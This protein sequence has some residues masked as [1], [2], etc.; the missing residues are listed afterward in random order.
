MR[1]LI[2]EEPPSWAALWSPRIAWLSVLVSLIALVLVRYGFVD[3]TP[4]VAAVLSGLALALGAVLL[5]LW[6]FVRIWQEG[7]RGVAS[8]VAGL[9][10]GLLV[11]AYPAFLLARGAFLP[12]LTDITTDIAEPPAFSRSRAA[13]TARGGWVP[14]EIAPELRAR[15]RAAYPRTA[16]LTLDV[17]ADEAFE[18]VRRVAER[19]GWQV[20]EAARPGGR[21]GQ[22]RLDAV[23]RTR[24]LRL[25][26]DVTVRVRP[27]VDGA[28]IDVRSATRIGGHDLGANADLIRSFLEDVSN[29]AIAL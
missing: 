11:L 2:I 29:L 25:P 6:G 20:V 19:R 12:P 16:S 4:G 13:V 17:P 5:A 14:P 7:Q 23:A 3:T 15:Q 1:R 24:V 10:V 27:R 9:L 22:G 18:L 26:L 28:R 21:I 8:A